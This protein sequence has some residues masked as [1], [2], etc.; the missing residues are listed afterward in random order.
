MIE[1][2][3][4]V[5]I[6]SLWQGVL[7]ALAGGGLTVVLA[8]PKSSASTASQ[9]TAVSVTPDLGRRSAGLALHGGF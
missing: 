1:A 3:C 8:A 9:G 7:L 2:I 4:W 6:H 5:L